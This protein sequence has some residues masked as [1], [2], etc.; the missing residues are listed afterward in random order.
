MKEYFANDQVKSDGVYKDD[1]K[2]GMFRVYS[3]DGLLL[4]I[5]VY[6]NDLLVQNDAV[7]LKLDIKRDYYNNGRP[8]SSVTLINGVKSG[9]YRDYDREGKITSSKIYDKNNIVAEGGT[10]DGSGQQQGHWKYFFNNGKVKSEGNYKNGKKDSV[11]TFYYEN[12]T[13]QLIFVFS[14]KKVCCVLF[15]FD[16]IP[17]MKIE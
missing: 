10:V 5:E 4:K 3:A 8:K 13:I 12:E 2:N 15:V 11:W 14:S 17:V 9:V 1:K 16:L 6:K 7:N